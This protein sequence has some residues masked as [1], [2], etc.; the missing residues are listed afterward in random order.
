MKFV[1]ATSSSSSSASVNSMRPFVCSC[2]PDTQ[3]LIHSLFSQTDFTS[4]PEKILASTR[5]L[6]VA[7]LMSTSELDARRRYEQALESLAKT[8][9]RM[10]RAESKL[11]RRAW[12]AIQRSGGVDLPVT[13]VADLGGD[14]K[15]WSDLWYSALARVRAVVS[16]KFHQL[17]ADKEQEL[18]KSVS[19]FHRLNHV[20]IIDPASNHENF[21]LRKR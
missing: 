16:D 21:H 2:A 11:L 14:A 10:R 3:R 13:C 20:F 15:R 9:S 4:Y 6:L 18:R 7:A 5:H 19:F 17:I 1:A 8:A 12:V